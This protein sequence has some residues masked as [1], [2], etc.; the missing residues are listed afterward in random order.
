M[1]TSLYLLSCTLTLAQGGERAEWQISPNLAPGLELVY[2]G[3]YAEESLIPNAAY[4]KTYRVDT[5]VLV[6][7]TGVKDWQLAIMTALKLQDARLPNDKKDGPSSVR[8]DLLRI[9]VEGRM[10]TT[11]KQLFHLPLKGPPTLESGMFVPAP[12]QKVGR[13]YIWDL[14]DDKR[15]TH[16][17]QAAG[18]ESVGGI[19]C[20][21]VASIQQSNDWA[22]PRADSAA[23]RR[24][25]TVWLHPQLMV[26]QKLE[27][28]IEHRDPARD[29][30]TFRT[31]VRYELDRHLQY[32]GLM[33]EERRKEVLKASKFS[34]EAQKL[35]QQPAL[36]RPQLDGLIRQVS[37]HLDHQPATQTTPYRKAFVHLK[38]VLEKAQKGDV[39]VPN[40]IEEPTPLP[41]TRVLGLGDRIPDFVVSNVTDDKTTRSQSLHGKPI[42]VIFYNPATQLGKEVMTYASKVNEKQTGKL[43]ILAMAVTN[44]PEITR[45]QH[46]NMKL[47]F[48]ALD[49]NAMRLP[50]GAEQTP[51]FVVVD[52]GGIV[53]L[54]LTGWG[55]QTPYEID[56]VLE[57]CLKK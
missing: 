15:P 31:V 33:F 29:T 36:N 34:D 1:L 28:I 16:R 38:A 56:D 22:V 6:L 12:G 44:E 47:P 32:P 48:P 4:Q 46:T 5:N 13:N 39:P 17:W 10:R 26:A 52:G 7:E 21:K 35:F 14:T 50:F 3:T 23:W 19:T 40:G 49:G 42:V 30:P 2:S 55:F 27:R 8:L 43:H 45:K 53:R 41:P 18:T 25:D 11:G 9:D 54:T 51:R 37:Y 20:I 24:R 57:R